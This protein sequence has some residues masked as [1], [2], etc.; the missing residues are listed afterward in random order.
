MPTA[1]IMYAGEQHGFR[2]ADSIRSAYDS[3]LFFYGKVLG[4]KPSGIGEDV[5]LPDVKNVVSVGVE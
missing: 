4:F 1:L 5:Q 2:K 3:E